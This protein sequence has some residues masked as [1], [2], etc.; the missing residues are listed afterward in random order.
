MRQSNLVTCQK[1]KRKMLF[2]CRNIDKCECCLKLFCERCV[3]SFK[4]KNQKKN[5]IDNENYLQIEHDF[6]LYEEFINKI[7]QLCVTNENYYQIFNQILCLYTQSQIQSQKLKMRILLDLKVSLK[8]CS[9][10]QN[11]LLQLSQQNRNSRQQISEL[12]LSQSN[13]QQLRIFYSD[14]IVQKYSNLLQAIVN[15]EQEPISYQNTLFKQFSGLKGKYIK[16][17]KFDGIQRQFPKYFVVL[18]R[19]L[20]VY[21]QEQQFFSQFDLSLGVELPNQIYLPDRIKIPIKCQI[22]PVTGNI[23]AIHHQK[24]LHFVDIQSPQKYKKYIFRDLIQSLTPFGKNSKKIILQFKGRLELWLLDNNGI[25]CLKRFFHPVIQYYNNKCIVLQDSKKIIWYSAFSVLTI[26][27]I[28][29]NIEHSVLTREYIDYNPNYFQQNVDELINDILA[30]SIGVLRKFSIQNIKKINNQLL[31][32]QYQDYIE[33]RQIADLILI[34]R[35]E[36]LQCESTAII[37]ENILLLAKTKDKTNVQIVNLQ[38]Y[39]IKQI[40]SSKEMYTKAIYC[41]SK[42]YLVKHTYFEISNRN[43]YFNT[44]VLD[45]YM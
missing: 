33:I 42:L 39:T 16:Q 18:N 1:H 34:E 29:G 40:F 36:N 32:I 26:N 3:S 12:T 11:N 25:R 31:L 28:T 45:V 8:I 30:Q 38:D 22:T 20:Y 2:I 37:Y 15:A 10:F 19:F 6:E 23:I 4:K 35:I 17:Q 24:S 7:E 43:Q 44:L 5:Y 14:K 13:I 9:V 41:D 21:N 27:L